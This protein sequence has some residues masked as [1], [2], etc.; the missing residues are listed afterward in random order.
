[1]DESSTHDKEQFGGC[2]IKMSQILSRLQRL[3]DSL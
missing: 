1:M 3:K 2:L